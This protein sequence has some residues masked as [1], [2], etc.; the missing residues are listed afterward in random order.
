MPRGRPRKYDEDQALSGAML[1][2]WERGF[3]A[4]SLDDLSK[5]MGMNRPS[6]YNAFGDKEAIY[7]KALAR[8]CEQLDQGIEETR[9]GFTG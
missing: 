1:L 7:A 2:F 5:A 9:T 8:F 6:I 3:S 4:T